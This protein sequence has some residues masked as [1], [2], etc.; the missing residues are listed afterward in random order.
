MSDFSCLSTSR[1]LSP[2]LLCQGRQRTAVNQQRTNIRSLGQCTVN[3]HRTNVRG[4]VR[5]TV[6][7]HRTNV[8][9]TVYK[10][11]TNV[12]C[13]VNKQRTNVNIDHTKQV[14]TLSVLIKHGKPHVCFMHH[15][16]TACLSAGVS[17][18]NHRLYFGDMFLFLKLAK[19]LK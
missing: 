1:E 3:E 5:C 8:R 11:R 15:T 12:R 4:T 10:H 2:G 16:F 13:T 9:C 7:K 6:N 19:L 17:I 18:E 14:K